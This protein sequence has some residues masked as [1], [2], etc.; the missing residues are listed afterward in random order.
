[1]G[2]TPWGEFVGPLTDGLVTTL[3]AFA[4]AALIATMAGLVFGAMR[5]SRR[6]WIRLIAIAYVEVFRGV[7][8]LVLLFWF[9]YALPLLGILVPAM[10]AACLVI[11]LNQGAFV[12]E[13]VRASIGSVPVGQVEA[14]VAI[15]LTPSDRFFRV[16]LPQ[17]LPLA[18]PPY[19]NHL[20]NALKETSI[21]SLIGLTDLTFRAQELRTRFGESL[22]IFLTI[23]VVY[24]ALA[25]VLTN[26]VAHL[27]RRLRHGQQAAPSRRSRR[28]LPRLIRERA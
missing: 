2:D 16:I 19:G 8:V 3:T 22:Q 13:I 23:A 11:G 9:F 21:V 24:F 6:R 27:S 20:V 4:G 25:W 14:S 10:T 26:V 1:M 5:M 28:L 7:S 12:S 17:A 18:L 15:N